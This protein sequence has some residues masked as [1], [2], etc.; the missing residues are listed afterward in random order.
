M[1][2]SINQS[3]ISDESYLCLVQKYVQRFKYCNNAMNWL[4][5]HW[6]QRWTASQFQPMREQQTIQPTNQ[7][8]WNWLDAHPCR[9]QETHLSAIATGRTNTSNAPI[10]L[11]VDVM[12]SKLRDSSKWFPQLGAGIRVWQWQS[13]TI[14]TWDTGQ[15]GNEV[16]TTC[17]RLGKWCV[18][19]WHAW[20]TF[21]AL[22]W[23]QLF[24]SSKSP[25]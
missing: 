25:C 21:V 14:A 1:K 10:P 22:S 3:R 2:R 13:V 7:R 15:S 19:G 17:W 16:V 11:T 24:L 23:L 9:W 4:L 8:P 18:H 6:G 5:C 20:S 12:W